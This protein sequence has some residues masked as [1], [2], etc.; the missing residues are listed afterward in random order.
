M[1]PALTPRPA[2]RPRR[3]VREAAADRPGD[4]PASRDSPRSRHAR[5]PLGLVTS[6]R[7][8]TTR[9]G[10]P[11]ALPGAPAS[12]S[13]CTSRGTP[14][15]RHRPR[16]AP[17]A[18]P[19]S[20]P[21]AR[22]RVGGATSAC[23][24][25]PWVVD[26]PC[27]FTP[28]LPQNRGRSRHPLH[29]S[30]TSTPS[31]TFPAAC[32]DSGTDTRAPVWYKCSVDNHLC[33]RGDLCVTTDTVPQTVLFPDLFDKPLHAQFN[34][35]QASSDGGA[36]LLKAAERIYGLVKALAG[37]PFDKRAPDKIRHSLADLIGQRIFGI[38]CG[39][40]DCNDGD[41]LAARPDGVDRCPLASGRR[42]GRPE[43]SRATGQ[44]RLRCVLGL[45]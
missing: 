12:R 1:W 38:A 28:V 35:E 13:R 45:P 10:P 7:V 31:G 25:C 17:A 37:C 21:N 30:S 11:P 33:H 36:V 34:H 5:G 41:R 6:L 42:R 27:D 19:G 23:H 2:P 16:R 14:A 20:R 40:P 29:L 15:G 32:A 26:P 24:A 18:A 4:R 39:H 3:H 9:P 43:A 22:L 44:R 8:R